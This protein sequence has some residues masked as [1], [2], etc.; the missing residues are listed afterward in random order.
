MAELPS[1][2]SLAK[3]FTNISGIYLD[4]FIIDCKKRADGRVVGR[5]AL[6]PSELK[7]AREKLKSL[8]RPMDIWVTLYS[9]ELLPKHPAHIGCDPPLANFLDLFDV[10][11]LWTWNA[12]ELPKLE[13]SLAVLEIVAPKNRRIALGMYIWDYPHSRPVPLD[14]MRYQCELGLKW[15]KEKRIQE[16]IFLANTVLDVG[17]PGGEFARSWITKVGREPL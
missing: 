16:M 1:V 7:S 8:G 12:N 4:D 10:L 9:H 14:L 2:L 6:H 5:P 17:A 3:K 15:L 13:E 11:T